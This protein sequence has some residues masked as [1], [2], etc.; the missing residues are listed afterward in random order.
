M[1]VWSSFTLQVGTPNMSRVFPLNVQH[2]SMWVVQPDKETSHGWKRNL[3]GQ[4]NK[5]DSF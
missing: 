3:L 2:F 5:I 4:G 1:T